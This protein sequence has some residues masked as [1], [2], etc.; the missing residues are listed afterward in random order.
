MTLCFFCVWEREWGLGGGGKR[1]G[2]RLGEENIEETYSALSVPGWKKYRSAASASYLVSFALQ[3]NT[4]RH[5]RVKYPA[6]VIVD[7]EVI[8]RYPADY[9]YGSLDLNRSQKIGKMLL[10]PAPQGMGAPRR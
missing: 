7:L 10:E 6:E 8:I 3:K 1:L 4:L 2:W 5:E 9:N